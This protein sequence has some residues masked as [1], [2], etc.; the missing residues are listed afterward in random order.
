MVVR[1]LDHVRT[2]STYED[3]DVIFNLIA[4]EV[5][6]GRDVTL[7]FNGVQAVPSAFIN[8][9]VVRLIERVPFKVIKEHLMIIDSTKQINELI[10]GRF[11]YLAQV[12]QNAPR[13]GVTSY[14]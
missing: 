6:A 3:G 10:K 12:E 11:D 7:S 5:E 8:A 4:P 9:A 13:R 1:V 2:C 14:P